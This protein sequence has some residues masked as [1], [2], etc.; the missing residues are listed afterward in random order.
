MFQRDVFEVDINFKIFEKD[1]R[2]AV[3]HIRGVTAKKG[4]EEASK[5]LC[6]A[7][8]AI[9]DAHTKVYEPLQSTVSTGG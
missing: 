4:L 8:A 2:T 3:T 6:V 7:A 1:C 5:D 9:S